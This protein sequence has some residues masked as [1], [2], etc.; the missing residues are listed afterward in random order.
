MELSY[1]TV[2]LAE[3]FFAPRENEIEET[4]EPLGSAIVIAAEGIFALIAKSV[5]P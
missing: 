4:L 1:V 3:P 5:V 2:A